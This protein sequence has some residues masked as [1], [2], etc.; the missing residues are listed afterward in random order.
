MKRWIAQS[1]RIVALPA[2]TGV[3]VKVAELFGGVEYSV[4]IGATVTAD[5]EIRIETTVVQ[6]VSFELFDRRNVPGV[7]PTVKLS[8]VGVATCAEATDALAHASANHRCSLIKDVP[9]PCR[10]PIVAVSGVHAGKY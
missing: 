5:P 3:T 7:P 4:I 8:V 2:F 1:T 10:W 9:L 6:S